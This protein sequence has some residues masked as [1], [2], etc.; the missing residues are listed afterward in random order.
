M[1]LQKPRH[2]SW[3]K[4]YALDILIESDWFIGV[5]S[6]IHPGA[7]AGAQ[8]LTCRLGSSGECETNFP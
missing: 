3:R 7:L 6:A 5:H 1:K 2:F 4:F 8:S